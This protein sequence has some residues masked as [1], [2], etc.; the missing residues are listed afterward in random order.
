MQTP[1]PHEAIAIRHGPDAVEWLDAALS[2]FAD[3]RHATTAMRWCAR[4]FA[5]AMALEKASVD[6]EMAGRFVGN[7]RRR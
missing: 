7:S 5:P 2:H 6:A 3:T 4:G 1:M